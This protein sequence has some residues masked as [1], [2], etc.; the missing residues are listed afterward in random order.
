MP[1]PT[2]VVSGPLMPTR[3]FLKASTVSSGSQLSKSFLRLLAGVDLDPGDLLLAAV[4]LLDRGVEHAHAGAP[5]V[6]AGAVAF[7][8]RDDRVVG[9]LEAPVGVDGDGVGSGGNLW[10]C[11]RHD[12]P[13]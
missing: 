11:A 1:P 8:E 10:L 5:D 13:D 6:G 7:D 12:G 3:Y 2:G 4:G 9:H